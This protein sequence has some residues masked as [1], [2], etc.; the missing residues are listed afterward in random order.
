MATVTPVTPASPPTSP[1][2]QSPAPAVKAKGNFKLAQSR[3]RSKR[4][5]KF[6][7]ETLR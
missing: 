2:P 4:L 5:Q 3:A 6:E 7:E 1:M